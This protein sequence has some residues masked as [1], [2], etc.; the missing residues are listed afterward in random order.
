MLL[1]LWSLVL[2]TIVVGGCG[3][4]SIHPLYSKDKEAT[5]DAIVGT[6]RSTD[7]DDKT[8]FEVS[9]A[10]DAYRLVTR[11]DDKDAEPVEFEVHLLQ[12]GK[13]RFAD[14]AAPGGD[15]KKQDEKWGPLFVPTHLFARYALDGDRLKV[16]CPNRQRLA[17]AVKDKKVQLAATTPKNNLLLITAETAELQK[18]MQE[19]AEDSGLYDMVQLERVKP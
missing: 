4:P 12:L 5:D 1:R 2:A 14:F 8:R 15:R 17:A 10:G 13:Y 7:K 19:H 18:F 11:T 6:W 16:W 9:R 3:T